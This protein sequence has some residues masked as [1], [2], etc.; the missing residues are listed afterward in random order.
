MRASLPSSSDSDG[1]PATVA[2]MWVESDDTCPKRTR[3]LPTARYARVFLRQPEFRER[4]GGLALGRTTWPSRLMNAPDW[5]KL[6]VLQFCSQIPTTGSDNGL[7][8]DSRDADFRHMPPP[9]RERVLSEGTSPSAHAQTCSGPRRQGASSLIPPLRPPFSSAHGCTT[10]MCTETLPPSLH[11]MAA[12]TFAKC[13]QLRA[14]S[15][16]QPSA[17]VQKLYARTFTSDARQRYPPASHSLTMHS[18]L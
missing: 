7:C 12:D 18:Y 3:H 5:L 11:P 9:V 4:M 16:S 6:M 14:S 17:T 8:C 2:S 15:V 10:K 1:L 13:G